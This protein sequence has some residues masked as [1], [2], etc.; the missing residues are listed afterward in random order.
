[1]TSQDQAFAPP[2]SSNSTMAVYKNPFGFSLQVVR[3][4]ENITLTDSGG[5]GVA[6][7]SQFPLDTA[8]NT[9]TRYNSSTF[10]WL[11]QLV[12]SQLATT[13]I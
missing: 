4:G 9:Y 13:Q 2:A 3:A 12:G 10:Q 1:M 5:T 11:T 6:T 8:S 7:V